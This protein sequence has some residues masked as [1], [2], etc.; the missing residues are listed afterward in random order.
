MRRQ[1]IRFD[2]QSRP[3]SRRPGI[4]PG[5]RFALTLVLAVVSLAC[6]GGVAVADENSGQT[7]SAQIYQ[8]S[9]VTSDSVSIADLEANSGCPTYS[10]PNPVDLYGSN[11]SVLQAVGF[12]DSLAW[13]LA[14]VLKCLQDPVNISAITGVTVTNV[15]GAPEESEGSQLLPGDLVAPTD[16]A[17]NQEAPLVFSDGDNITYLR[18]WR[19]GTDNNYND[20]VTEPDPS[21]LEIQVFEGPHLNVVANPASDAVSAG[22]TVSFSAT[23]TEAGGGTPSTLSYS[24]NFDGAAPTSTAS[25]PQVP[26]ASAGTYDVTVEVTDPD[27]GSG[28]TTIPITVNAATTPATT[29]TAPTGPTSSNG[30]VAGGKK[31]HHPVKGTTSGKRGSPKPATSG[32]HTDK[33]GSAD[34]GT[35]PA[36]K[37]TSGTSSTAGVSGSSPGESATTSRHPAATPKQ[38]GGHRTTPVRAPAPPARNTAPQAPR[39]VGRL[40]SDVTPLPA[41]ESPLVHAVPGALATAPAVRR[42]ANPSLL[43]PLVAGFAV[44]VLFSLGAGRELRGRRGWRAVRFGS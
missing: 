14:T 15:D 37:G 16:F 21:P 7:V 24:W 19:G 31:G 27:G 9:G 4:V 13:S 40:V 32:T 29:S 23:V 3:A 30:N 41:G 43:P 8:S 2:E 38:S 42:S 18:P 6:S 1:R 35:T 28:G 34:H 10:G 17:N 39:I 36:S 44:F 20:K 5:R 25:T 22:A 26:F 33:P 12:Q 11:G